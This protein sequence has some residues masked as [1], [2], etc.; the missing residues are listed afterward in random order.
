MRS[1]IW[2][3]IFLVAGLV[4]AQVL[5]PPDDDTTTVHEV[6]EDYTSSS[7]P[8]PDDGNANATMGVGIIPKAKVGCYKKDGPLDERDVGLAKA[9]IVAWVKKW[10]IGPR[11]LVMR[12]VGTS[13]WY[14]CNCK[15][16]NYD[17][18]PA[19]ELDEVED[20]LARHCGGRL[21]PGWVWSKKWNKSYNMVSSEYVHSHEE[22]KLC[23]QHC[24]RPRR[25]ARP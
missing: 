9:Q 13:A 14:V 7:S 17:P 10:P 8:A 24:T 3:L 5:P 4:A 20:L 16:F 25:V 21:A 6:P 23:P 15:W 18:L 1:V 19:A 12:W 22:R 11:S 2:A